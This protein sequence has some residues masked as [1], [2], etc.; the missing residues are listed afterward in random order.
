[1][2]DKICKIKYRSFEETPVWQK[3]KDLTLIIC[4]LTNNFPKYEKFGIVSQ[5]RRSSSSICANIAEGFYRNT[6]KEL[7]SFLNI[8][9]GSCGETICFLIL[10]NELRYINKNE[11]SKLKNDC[12]EINKQLNSWIKSLRE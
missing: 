6:T 9:R 5:I 4:K 12:N 7:V 8:S 1:M 2:T 3:A 11:L 10:S